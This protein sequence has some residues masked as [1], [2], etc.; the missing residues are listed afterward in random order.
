MVKG[1]CDALDSLGL[2]ST[3]LELRAALKLAFS[4]GEIEKRWF[5]GEDVFCERKEP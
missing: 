3:P 5:R 4:D 2:V 1:V